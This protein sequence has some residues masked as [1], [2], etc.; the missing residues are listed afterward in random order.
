M[1]KMKSSPPQRHRAGIVFPYNSKEKPPVLLSAELRPKN[2]K[3]HGRLG[4]KPREIVA[5][6]APQR[7]CPPTAVDINEAGKQGPVAIG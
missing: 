5:D 4:C 3:N 2:R 7:W 1:Y 6:A